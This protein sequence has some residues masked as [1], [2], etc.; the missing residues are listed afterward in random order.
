MLF[1][2]TDK[3]LV[4]LMKQFIAITSIRTKDNEI[5]KII[6]CFYLNI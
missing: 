5:L 6:V 1:L 2:P 4:Q 3:Q